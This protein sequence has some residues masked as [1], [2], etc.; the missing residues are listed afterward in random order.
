MLYV[1]RV[2]TVHWGTG[3][4]CH[5]SKC[6]ALT[7]N[8]PSAPMM[9][10]IDYQ[11]AR[12]IAMIACRRWVIRTYG[13][14]DGVLSQDFSAVTK[15][16][17][18]IVTALDTLV[19]RFGWEAMC[20]EKGMPVPESAPPVAYFNVV[21]CAFHTRKALMAMQ[22]APRPCVLVS[23]A[24][25]L[26]LWPTLESEFGVITL[27]H[28]LLKQLAVWAKHLDAAELAS[29]IASAD[30]ATDVAVRS[31]AVYPNKSSGDIT[32]DVIA[33]ARGNSYEAEMLCGVDR[34]AVTVYVG[35]EA[36]FLKAQHSRFVVGRVAAA[37]RLDH[38]DVTSVSW[39][40]HKMC[41]ATGPIS[42]LIAR[43]VKAVSLQADVK[44]FQAA[45]FS[46][47]LAKTLFTTMRPRPTRLGDA[48]RQQLQQAMPSGASLCVY[49]C[50]EWKN[51]SCAK[52]AKA[53]EQGRVYL[54]CIW[55]KNIDEQRS[56]QAQ[57]WSQLKD[58]CEAQGRPCVVKKLILSVISILRPLWRRSKP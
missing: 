11:R 24:R 29:L 1:I 15:G 58:V 22:A 2:G 56:T 18:T 32:Q 5:E 38:Q 14:L 55:T 21:F 26:G 51:H 37:T 12:E 3:G 7:K 48:V 46:A 23:K 19:T 53:V 20:V 41:E 9:S 47:I 13:T 8:V 36:D 33:L 45:D 40:H 10:N 17:M 34:K 4:V 50:N 42:L 43:R 39:M 16:A 35:H 30:N 31:H 54:D 57:Q 6:D 27:R 49:Y 25:Y 44:E 28:G 52:A